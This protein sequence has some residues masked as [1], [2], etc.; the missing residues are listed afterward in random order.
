LKLQIKHKA[1]RN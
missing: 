1:Q